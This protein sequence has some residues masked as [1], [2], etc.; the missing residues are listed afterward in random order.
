MTHHTTDPAYSPERDVGDARIPVALVSCAD[1]EPSHVYEAMNRALSLLG[2]L[3]AYVSPGTRVLVKPNLLQGLPPGRAVCTHPSVMHAII[4]LLNEHGCT[5]TLADSP[6]AG[7]RY[8]RKNLQKQYQESGYSGLAGDPG[9]VL[10]LDVGFAPVKFQGGKVCKEFPLIDPFFSADHVI[11]VS[12]A[13]AHVLTL[14]TGA[15]KNLFGLIPGLEKPLFHSRFQTHERFGDML[16]DL[17][18]AVRPSLQVADAIMAMEGD[19]PTSGAPRYLGVLLASPSPLA[20][21]MVLCRLMSIDPIDVPYLKCAIERRLCAADGSDLSLLGDPLS[22]FIAADFKKPSTY[23]G[24]SEGMRISPVFR[25]VHRLGRIYGVRPVV[26]V[27]RCT[28][29]GKCATICP[30]RAITLSGSHARI[31]SREC[32]RCYCCHEMCSEGAISLKRGLVG[33]LLHWA[34]NER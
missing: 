11:V 18:M 31:R 33:S 34:L 12:K 21:D 3:K 14:L 13:K 9:C 28:G 23:R 32:I 6:G 5:V 10:N 20:L 30:A 8:T 1:Y 24:G 4:R 15:T 16:I 25:V 26:E 19:G 17:N 2:G 29:C 27:T 7:I 22:S